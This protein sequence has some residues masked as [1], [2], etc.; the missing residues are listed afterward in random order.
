[1]ITFKLMQVNLA[2]NEA[3]FGTND[4]H[5][6]LHKRMEHKQTAALFMQVS[7]CTVRF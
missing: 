5:R 2:V 4:I 7:T 6:L 3:S 1:M